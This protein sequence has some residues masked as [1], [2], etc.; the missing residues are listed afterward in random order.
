MGEGDVALLASLHQF[1]IDAL[2]RVHV[3]VV[4]AALQVIHHFK[5]QAAF[6]DAHKM[7]AIKA[8]Q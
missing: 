4:I 8:G 3:D 6:T 2:L 1:Q 7:R 5:I